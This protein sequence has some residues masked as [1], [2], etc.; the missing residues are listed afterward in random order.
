M[1]EQWVEEVTLDDCAIGSGRAG[2]EKVQ[3]KREQNNN[4]ENN[5]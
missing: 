2:S 3:E 1:R 5:K 4:N